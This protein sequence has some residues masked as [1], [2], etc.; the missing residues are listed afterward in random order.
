MA[1]AKQSAFQEIVALS[2]GKTLAVACLNQ[3]P[4][5]LDSSS[6]SYFMMVMA[7]IAEAKR[8]GI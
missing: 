2:D 4:V 3:V 6:M 1:R 7:G 5:T 8:R